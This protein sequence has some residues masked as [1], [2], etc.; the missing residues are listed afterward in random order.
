MSVNVTVPVAV[1]VLDSP[2]YWTV[3][4]HVLPGAPGAPGASTVVLVQVPPVMLNVPLPVPPVF[5]IDGA[6]VKVSGPAF[7]PVAVLLTVMVPVFVPVPPVVMLAGP[8]KPTV[9]DLT[10]K[11]TVLLVPFAVVTLTFLFPVPAEFAI[12]NVAVTLVALTL[13]I[14]LTVTPVP[15]TFTAVVPPRLVPVRVTFTAVPREPELGLMLDSVGA[16]D[17]TANVTV[18]VVP[19]GVTTLTFRVASGAV[20]E[21]VKVATTVVE[22]TTPMS[23]TVMPLPAP[24]D[25]LTA[26]AP[27]RFVPVRVTFTI[28]PRKPEVGFIEVKVAVTVVA[29]PW[30]ST[31]P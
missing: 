13:T 27:V 26:E 4:V 7:A 8:E 16:S 23:L 18:L 20:E 5:A 14:L 12:V 11:V 1:L 30:N 10:L 17:C 2:E 22:L 24:P 29:V 9:A 25:T 19:T 3:I 28:V 15:E 21:M 31:A 6:A